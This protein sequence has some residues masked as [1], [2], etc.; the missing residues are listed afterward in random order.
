MTRW[1][2][3][4]QNSSFISKASFGGKF[5]VLS[6]SKNKSCTAETFVF[7]E[8]NENSDVRKRLDSGIQDTVRDLIH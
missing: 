7:A 2:L 1:F 3:K 4:I 5:K 8:C 6:R